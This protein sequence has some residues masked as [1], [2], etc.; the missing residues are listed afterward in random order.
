[1][2]PHNSYGEEEGRKRENPRIIG[3]PIGS[4]ETQKVGQSRKELAEGR[5][6]NNSGSEKEKMNYS[7]E[8]DDM[9]EMGGDVQLN[10]AK[11]TQKRE[12]IKPL[13]RDQTRCGT[14]R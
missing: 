1:M 9:R 13:R 6:Q 8:R 4:K 10:L 11:E 5:G 2:R 12:E 3:G 14:K 7:R